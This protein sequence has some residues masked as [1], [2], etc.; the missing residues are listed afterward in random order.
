MATGTPTADQRHLSNHGIWF[1]VLLFLSGF[2][3]FLGY[4]LYAS[5]QSEFAIVRRDSE[6]LTGAIERHITASSEKVDIVLQETS[7]DYAR[8][9]EHPSAADVA[10]VNRDLLRREAVIPETQANSL[11]IIGPDGAVLFSAGES[12]DLPNVNVSDR[13]YFLRQVQDPA[14]GLVVSEPILS[15]FTGKWVFTLSR[16]MSR[17]D[18]SFAGL[19]QTAFRA[20]YFEAGFSAI[21]V[22]KEGVVA[23]FSTDFQL[24]ARHPSLDGMLGQRFELREIEEGLGRDQRSGS[25]LACSRVD[26][27]ERFFTYRKFEALPLLVNVG[28]PPEVFL[29]GWKEKAWIYLASWVCLGLALVGGV[30]L[31]VRHARRI[32]G[33]NALLN[34]QVVKA[35]AANRAKSAFLANMSHEIRTPLNVVSGMVSI[36]RREGVTPRQALRLDNMDSAT[37]H[38]LSVINNILDLSKIEAGKLVLEASPVSID[39]LM[40]DVIAILSERASAKHLDLRVESDPM[41]HNLVGDQTRL[42]QALLNYASNAI[43]FTE[44]GCI[45]LRVRKLAE[46]DHSLTLRFEVQDTGIGV[47]PETLSRLFDAF[48]QADNSMSRKYGGTGLGLAITRHLSVLMGGEAGAESTVGA[49]STF[50]FTAKLAKGALHVTEP[51]PLDMPVDAEKS[52]REHHPGARILVVDDDVMNREMA[53]AHLEAIGVVVDTAV[54]GLDAA[55]KAEKGRYAVILMDMQMPN[56]DGVDATRA[57]RQLDGLQ[58]V[59]II[60]LTANAFA[61]DKALCIEVGMNDFLSKPYTP[62]DLYRIVLRWLN[63]G[64][65]GLA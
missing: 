9:L 40:S 63:H 8:L 41:P 10:T 29:K 58:Q 6:N 62:D 54:D 39:T 47:A 31:T 57:I 52:I 50:W 20:E 64:R 32:E 34:A 24:V 35:E 11:R 59:P 61:E 2:G 33:L 28:V 48:E 36:L 12:A 44:N 19:V 7:H 37:H 17:P 38:L 14:A 30:L 60:A 16:R 42:Q 27:K 53:R 65:R 25:Y 56:C 4:E 55:A 18:G 23:L 49:G 3:A 13:N 26:S 22:G 1:C 5:Y 51:N 21:D 15:R 43:K 46:S 45:T